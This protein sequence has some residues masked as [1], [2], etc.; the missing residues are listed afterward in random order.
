MEYILV[1]QDTYHVEHY[2]RQE[3][4]SW[5]IFDA[6]GPETTI[7]LSAI[8]CTL[9]LEDVYEKVELPEGGEAR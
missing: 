5:H 2:V 1:A 7:S 3:D 6:I 8:N 9:A 4:G